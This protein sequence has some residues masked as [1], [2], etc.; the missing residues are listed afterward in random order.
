MKTL[1]MFLNGAWVEAAEGSRPD[2]SE[3]TI[4]LW[5]DEGIVA[6]GG[7]RERRGIIQNGSRRIG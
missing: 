1:P 4:D 5:I 6:R 3:W 2:G 7:R